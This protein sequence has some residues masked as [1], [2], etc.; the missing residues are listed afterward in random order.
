MTR[1]IKHSISG[2]AMVLVAVLFGACAT[3]T[4]KLTVSRNDVTAGE[5]VTVKRET[6]DAKEITLNGE[7]VE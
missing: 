3:P 6:K 5:P 7:K 2:L 4:A 1:K